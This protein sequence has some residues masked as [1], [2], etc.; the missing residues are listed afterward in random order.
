MQGSL[1]P[2]PAPQDGCTMLQSPP[3]VHT[4][5]AFVVERLHQTQPMS[6]PMSAAWQSAQVVKSAQVVTGCCWQAS[7]L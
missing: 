4:S 5:M 1:L 2:P 3:D 7:P 6:E